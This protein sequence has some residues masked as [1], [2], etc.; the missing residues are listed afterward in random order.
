[1]NADPRKVARRRD[2][3]PK[4]VFCL[5]FDSMLNTVDMK[6]LKVVVWANTL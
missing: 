4:E 6:Q 2:L 5:P 1:M 3:V